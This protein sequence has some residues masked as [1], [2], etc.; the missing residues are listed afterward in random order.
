MKKIDSDSGYFE[1]RT[2]FQHRQSQI[3]VSF[4]IALMLVI[5][6]VVFQLFYFLFTGQ[7][8]YFAP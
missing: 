6:I 4:I 7:F 5:L 2:S 8:F 1:F 3:K